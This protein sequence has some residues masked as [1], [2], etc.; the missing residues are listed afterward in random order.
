LLRDP[1]E[2]DVGSMSHQIL[3]RSKLRAGLLLY[4]S[5]DSTIFELCD[6][7]MAN[8]RTYSSLCR[9]ILTRGD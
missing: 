2:S 5:L 9:W 3:Q 1:L 4:S 8:Q 6:T 7:L